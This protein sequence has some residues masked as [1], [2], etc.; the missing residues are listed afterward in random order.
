MTVELPYDPAISLPCIYLKKMKILTQ[1]DVSTPMSIV[2]L[3]IIAKIWKQLKCPLMNEWIKK[4]WKICMYIFQA[5]KK[6][7]ISPFVTIWID[8][9]GL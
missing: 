5:L 7:E 4:M 2:T 6:N 1:K 9:E 8:I 3:F